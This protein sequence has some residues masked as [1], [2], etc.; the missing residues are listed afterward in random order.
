MTILTLKQVCLAFGHKPI[1]DRVNFELQKG[2]KICL[3]GRNGVGKSTLFKTILADISPDEGSIWHPDT[4]K[5]ASLAQDIPEF[6][7]KSIYQVV[8]EGFAGL[9]SLLQQYHDLAENIQQ[10]DQQ[11]VKQLEKIQHQID[12]MNGWAVDQKIQSILTRLNLPADKLI[13]QCSG[14]IKRK[15]LLAKALVDEPDLLLL[16]EPTNHMDINAITWLEE[17]LANY[18]G[19]IIFVTH[20]RAFLRKLAKRIIELDRGRLTSFAG[21][22][23]FYL[24]AK[25]NLIAEEE[26]AQKRL[27]KKLEDYEAWIRQGVKARGKRNQGKV[28]KLLELRE[29]KAKTLATTGKIKLNSQNSQLSGKLVADLDHIYFSYENK[30]IIKD[31]SCRIQRQDRIGIIGPNGCG[32]STLLNIIL[33]KSKPQSGQV[34]LGTKLNIAYFDQQRQ[35]LDLE[36]SVKEN[37]SDGNDYIMLQNQS[38]HVISYLKDFLFPADKIDSP[39]KVLSGGEKNRLLLA[40]LFTY[41]S[42]LLVLDEPTNDLDIETLELLEDKLSDYNG[43]LLIVSHDRAFLDNLVTSTIVF[44]NQ[45]AGILQEYVGGYEDYIRQRNKLTPSNVNQ[46][47]TA[48]TDQNKKIEA[49]SN[50]KKKLS[51]KET[52]ELNTLPDEIDRLEKEIERLEQQISQADFYRQEKTAISRTLAELEDLRKQLQH[53]YQRWEHLDSYS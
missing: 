35:Q 31:F 30:T 32:K 44:E 2:E 21:D 24:K 11:S 42:N 7:N 46:K 17:F 51:Y 20:D 4:L 9:S 40:R 45:E 23:D 52:H 34:T 14:G 39:V 36:K 3:I 33:G 18:N 10:Q 50:K 48:K 22:F 38:K 47:K 28:K 27:N 6:A 41:E 5:I 29:Q 49:N 25:E 53:A 19:S 43:T 15:T 1:L 8:S 16:D 12:A 26:N 13:K 37:I